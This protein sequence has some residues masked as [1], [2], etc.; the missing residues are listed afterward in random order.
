M[1]KIITFIHNRLFPP[2]DYHKSYVEVTGYWYFKI[3]PNFPGQGSHTRVMK[4]DSKVEEVE[5]TY[6]DWEYDGHKNEKPLGFRYLKLPREI[7]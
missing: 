1:K 6:Y 7:K 2:R 5:L 3:D 4:F